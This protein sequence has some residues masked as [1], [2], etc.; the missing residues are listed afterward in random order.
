MINDVNFSK[1]VFDSTFMKLS[2]LHEVFVV[3][4]LRQFEFT[5]TEKMYE[6]LNTC[7][8]RPSSPIKI[9]N[10]MV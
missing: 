7:I 3:T 10:Q 9:I 5:I 1:H 4:S 2:A 6:T 8:G